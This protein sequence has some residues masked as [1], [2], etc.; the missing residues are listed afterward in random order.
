MKSKK[1]LC[2][3]LASMI[4]VS[5][6]AGAALSASAADS[7]VVAVSD[8]VAEQNQITAENTSFVVGTGNNKKVVV[9]TNSASQ[10]VSIRFRDEEIVSSKTSSLVSIQNGEVTVSSKVLHDISEFVENLTLV[11]DDGTL[12]ITVFDFNHDEDIPYSVV[13]LDDGSGCSAGDMEKGD[14][15]EIYSMLFSNNPRGQYT[16]SVYEWDADNNFAVV[17]NSTVW[18]YQSEHED[19]VSDVTV[20]YDKNADQI[21]LNVDPEYDPNAPVELSYFENWGYYIEDDWCAVI[22]TYDGTDAE[23]TVPETI[24]DFPVMKIGENI[25]KDHKEIV[26]VKLPETVDNIGDSA[27]ENCT[28]LTSVNLPSKLYSISGNLFKGCSSLTEITIPD[29]V[30]FMGVS[31]FENCTKLTNVTLSKKT[32]ELSDN[33]F[34][35]CKSLTEITVPDSVNYIGQKVFENCTSLKTVVLPKSIQSL[36][37]AAFKNCTALSGEITLTDVDEI[38]SYA[39]YG[40]RSLEKVTFTSSQNVVDDV[41]LTVDGMAFGNCKSLKEVNFLMKDY[42]T[43][44]KTA[45]FNCIKVKTI[46]YT[47]D[48][49]KWKSNVK[50]ELLGNLFFQTAMVYYDNVNYAE[51]EKEEIIVNVGEEFALAYHSAPYSGVEAEFKSITWESTNPD[52]AEVDS[53]GNVNTKATGTADIILTSTTKSGYTHQA[54]CKV[55]AVKP[56]ESITLNKTAVNI[57]VSQKY[58]LAATVTPDG[59]SQYIKWST[60]DKYIATVDQSGVV[61]GKRTGTVTITAKTWDGKKVT[62]K[63]NVKRAPESI[64]LDRETLTM[65]ALSTYQFTKT[66]SDKNSATSY[67][68]ESSNPDVVKVYSTGKIVSLAPGTAVITVTTHNGKSASCTV[69]VK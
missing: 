41:A 16:I 37:T 56:T 7:N 18:N 50:T 28:S 33:I 57:G 8:G 9:K 59:A 61:T 15:E 42:V 10:N 53:E 13:M 69:T 64:Q 66:L 11:F 24:E 48:R 39:F 58:A 45:F 63:V 30:E 6:T 62:C 49:S 46:H 38:P 67:K 4:I 65:N 29:M 17:K 12:D 3:I 21:T 68:W 27:F 32:R 25:F 2:C 51:L 55:T 43:V 35:N 5:T 47:G 54:I 22:M 34:R 26:S 1:I 23:V 31:V 60:S 40:C 36:G 44:K 14:S 19:W 20:V 52:V